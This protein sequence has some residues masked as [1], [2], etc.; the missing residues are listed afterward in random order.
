MEKRNVQFPTSY[1]V[2]VRY[3][4]FDRVCY[5]FGHQEL[6]V[7]PF[8]HPIMVSGYKITLKIMNNE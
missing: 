8:W 5:A 2:S 7:A 4:L 1:R 3:L 6:S